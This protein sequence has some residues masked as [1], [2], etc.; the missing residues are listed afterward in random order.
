MEGVP[1]EEIELAEVVGSTG[2]SHELV[3][4]EDATLV[5]HLAR[6]HALEAP[7]GMS[8][9]TLEGLHDRLHGEAHATDA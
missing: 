7:V 1:E 5:D 9:A 6:D 3:S 4:S 2:H 8:A